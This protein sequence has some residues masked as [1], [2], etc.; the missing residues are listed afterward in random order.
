MLS[1]YT[2]ILSC[3][4]IVN[5]MW[6]IDILQPALLYIKNSVRILFYFSNR[7]AFVGIFIRVVTFS[8]EKSFFTAFEIIGVWKREPFLISPTITSFMFLTFGKFV[9]LSA[10]NE[11]RI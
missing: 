6:F 1:P 11:L 9:P 5:K 3:H 8:V 2:S 10:A 7:K 4:S